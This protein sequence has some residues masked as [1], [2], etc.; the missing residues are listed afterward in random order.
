MNVHIFQ[1][2]LG[3]YTTQACNRIIKVTEK[4]TKNLFINVV[5]QRAAPTINGVINFGWEWNKIINYLKSVDNI[6]KVYFHCY[7]YFSQYLL[8]KLKRQNH[9]IKFIWI[10]WSGEFYN[11]PDFLNDIAIG[12][13]RKFINSGS[14]WEKLKQ[15][16]FN[17]QEYL[18]DKPYYLHGHYIKSFKQ[19]DFFAAL[20]E[21]DWKIVTN[22]AKVSFEYKKFAYLS[23]DQFIPVLNIQPLTLNSN[24]DLRLMI[25]H[26]GDPSLNHLD[27]IERLKTLNFKGKVILPL[28]Y[29]NQNYMEDL[30]AEIKLEFNSQ[31]E[32][33]DS[34]LEP[35]VYANKL[36]EI[37]IAIFNSKIQQGLG[38]IIMLVWFGAKIFLREEN[39]IYKEFKKWGISVY[40]IQN[41]LTEENLQLRLTESEIET[42]RNVLRYHLSDEA[43]NSYY[44]SLINTK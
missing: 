35:S 43:V 34:F 3:H 24:R 10:F 33:W 29:G 37:D 15:R 38:N 44:Y 39:T 13:S 8:K 18:K 1:D 23:F 17:F 28:S 30:K 26:S 11:L 14:K 40:S 31:A 4:D 22:Y 21:E 7:N 25:N 27:A 9:S 36:S 5:N 42:N 20:L 16:I 41:E 19:I 2:A 6:E 12:H 32:I